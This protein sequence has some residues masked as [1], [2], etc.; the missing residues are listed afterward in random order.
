MECCI[1]RERERR[2]TINKEQYD[3][4][5]DGQSKVYLSRNG[6]VLFRAAV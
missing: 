6:W 5:A 3:G 4:T 2:G 1:E